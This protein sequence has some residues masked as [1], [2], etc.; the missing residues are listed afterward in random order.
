MPKK[1]GGGLAVED[2][3][4]G[5]GANPLVELP[6][7][8]HGTDRFSRRP[9]LFRKS[10]GSKNGYPSEGGGGSREGLPGKG[11]GRG[12]GEQADPEPKLAL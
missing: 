6:T 5:V 4:P 8:E 2:R 10:E 11:H 3:N 7:S 1:D 12:L 9:L